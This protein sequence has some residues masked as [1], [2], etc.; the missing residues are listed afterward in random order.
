MKKVSV[1]AGQSG[2]EIVKEFQ[3]RGVEVLLICGKVG[4]SGSELADEVLICDLSL[5]DS[6][7]DKI[8]NYSRYLFLG[9]GHNLAINIARIC[10]QKELEVNFD[11]EIAKLFKSKL[12]THR[13]VSQLGYKTPLLHVING[14]DD[15]FSPKIFPVI[16]KSEEDSYKTEM[17]GSVREF[18]E[19]RDRI[20]DSNSVV[21]VEN[22][23]SGFEVTIPVKAAIN[24]VEACRASL[25]MEGI[26]TKA[27]SILKGFDNS[28]DS[29]NS[30]LL[31]ESMQDRIVKIVEHIISESKYTGY[32]RFDIIIGTDS[33]IYILEI[34]SIMV[35]AVGGTHYP[36]SEV[37][38][39]PAS[40][41]V[42]QFIGKG[43]IL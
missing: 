21:V 37:G 3:I 28:G 15:N 19:V 42:D 24:K 9:T 29:E 34:N 36:W 6:I 16:L 17:V 32:P 1:I 25:S 7:V 10:A 8:E 23:I 2:E 12:K 33:E 27:V 39:N 18:M 41:M 30:G 5:T 22:Y 13:F 31:T 14:S 35:T 40:D 26:N 43:A 4:E 20:L 38:M 11:T